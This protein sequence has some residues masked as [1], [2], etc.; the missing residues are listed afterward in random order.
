MASPMND[1]CICPAETRLLERIE[2][3]QWQI[4]LLKAEL[5]GLE[6]ARHGEYPDFNSGN[7]ELRARYNQG[8]QTWREIFQEYHGGTD[9]TTQTEV[10]H[11]ST[12]D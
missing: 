5:V 6:S 2:A 7:Q 9:T 4:E 1:T 12:E 11:G 8:R 10:P 3:V